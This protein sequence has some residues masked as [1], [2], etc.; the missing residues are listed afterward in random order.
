MV[1]CLEMLE[2]RDDVVTLRVCANVTACEGL[3]QL[4]GSKEQARKVLAR[5]ALGRGGV[6]LA[7]GD[8]LEP[9]DEL[10]FSLLAAEPAAASD[11]PVQVVYQDRL[12]MAVDKPAGILVHS[13]GS[14]ADTL[15]ARVQGLLARQGSVATA[16][17]VQRLDVETSGLVLFSLTREFQ[18]ALD[19]QVAGHDMHK[20]YLAVV[21]G[22]S[23]PPSTAPLTLS[24][25]IARDRH[26]AKRMRVG[27]GGKPST[28]IIRMLQRAHGR[29]L[30]QVELLTGRR[31]QIRVH[32]AH[33]GHP[34]V[35]DALY[36]GKPCSEGLILHAWQERAVHPLTGEVICLETSWPERFE[37]MGFDAIR[38]R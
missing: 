34:I 18:P 2:L 8:V 4:L 21:E 1:Q 5:G 11:G 22:T 10:V 26:D 24:W 27:R 7:G 23:W 25:P 3:A 12:M 17:A 14:G 28:T 13:D 36:G 29:T 20:R 32:L 15:T 33:A 19:A 35:G 38:P 16:Q 9:G 30:L 31:H 6:A 37:R